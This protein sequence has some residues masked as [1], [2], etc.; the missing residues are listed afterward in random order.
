M[1]NWSYLILGDSISDWQPVPASIHEVLPDVLYFC[2]HLTATNHAN[3]DTPINWTHA[4]FGLDSDVIFINDDD[5]D[6]QSTASE[7][8]MAAN[9]LDQELDHILTLLLALKINDNANA[10][11][12]DDDDNAPLTTSAATTTASYNNNALATATESRSLDKGLDQ[13]LTLLSSLKISDDDDDT[14]ISNDDNDS[15]STLS[16]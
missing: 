1:K 2:Q 11:I 13:I 14:L 4:N 9:V 5:D 6:A 16:A 3:R 8:T 12:S 7:T 15:P 10:L